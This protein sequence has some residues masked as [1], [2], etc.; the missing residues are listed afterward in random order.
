VSW[1]SESWKGSDRLFPRNVEIEYGKIATTQLNLKLQH[2]L[3]D[4]LPLGFEGSIAVGELIRTC[5]FGDGSLVRRPP[6]KVLKLG[7][8]IFASFSSS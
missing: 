5:Q 4:A 1:L 2:P 7:H 3:L 6:V 8:Y